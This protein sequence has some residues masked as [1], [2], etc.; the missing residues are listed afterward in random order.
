VL[1]VNKEVD[2]IPTPMAIM[3]L[4][5]TKISKYHWSVRNKPYPGNRKKPMFPIRIKND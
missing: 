4:W 5:K 2:Y 1:S 3:P